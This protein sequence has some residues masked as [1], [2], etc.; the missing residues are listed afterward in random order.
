M[1]TVD[2][3][4][5]PVEQTRPFEPVPVLRDLQARGP[6][7]RVRTRSGH[8][9]W[10]VTGHEQVRR[11]LGDDRLGRSHPDP[12]N[13]ARA[14]DSALFGG[15]M[16]NYETE[17]ADHARM[18]SLLQPHFSPKLMRALR[19]GIEALAKDLVDQVAGSTPPVDLVAAL[20]E[21]LPVLVICELLGVPYADRASF[22]EWT[23]AATDMLDRERSGRGLAEL[24]GYG[25]R[26]IASKR[27]NP[28]D[29]M[30]SRMCANDEL[31]DDEIAGLA[32][33]LLLA[34]HE[35]TVVQIGLGALQ[36][37]A[38]P[39][40]FRAL[41]E[42]PGLV[43][44]AVEEMLR[45]RSKGGVGTP[46]YARADIDTDGVTI[47]AGE[48]VLLDNGA[49]NHDPAVFADPDRF[50]LTRAAGA[51]LTFGHG[52]YYCLGAPLARI[53]LQA[54]FTQLARRLPTLRLAVPVESL[55]LRTGHLTGG[56]P[57]LPVTWADP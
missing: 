42:N 27:A 38:N 1:V 33:V 24:F 46:R 25:Q 45:T 11:L 6:I 57:E 37:L 47:R 10:L 13:A 41:R 56:L 2:L 30:I 50:D 36:L 40:Q 3:P 9:A 14:G 31:T 49:A 16:G 17:P 51:Q 35:S 53:E 48:L 15:P 20:A 22:R 32:M 21:P 19:P 43:E 18:R 4:E 23:L 7:H 29:D 26:L 54:L 28:G 5:F 34:G 52:G 12:D 44:G 55:R 8:E 39:D